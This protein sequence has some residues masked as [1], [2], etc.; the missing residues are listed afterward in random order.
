MVTRSHGLRYGMISHVTYFMQHGNDLMLIVKYGVMT[1]NFQ[2]TVST[3]K[4]CLL[5]CEFH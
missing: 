4:C 1:R 2:T 5:G 3:R